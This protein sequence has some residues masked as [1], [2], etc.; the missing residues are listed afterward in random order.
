M[1]TLHIDF[2]TDVTKKGLAQLFDEKGR[3]DLRDYLEEIRKA[4]PS[5]HGIIDASE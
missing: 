3:A 4:T 5:S 2:P 1:I